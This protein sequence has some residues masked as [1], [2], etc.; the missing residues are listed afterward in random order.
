M[1][2]PNGA[3]EAPSKE[4]HAYSA[5]PA[6]PAYLFIADIQHPLTARLQKLCFSYFMLG[7]M[8]PRRMIFWQE[9]NTSMVGMEI[10]T[11]PALTTH[12]IPPHHMDA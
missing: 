6:Y 7:M 2:S 1:L 11:N 10:T 8:I 12:G 5:Y 9:M 3:T 4:P